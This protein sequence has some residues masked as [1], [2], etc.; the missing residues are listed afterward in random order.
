MVNRDPEI[1]LKVPLT[2]RLTEKIL[3]LKQGKIQK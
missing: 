3:G 2:M 1:P